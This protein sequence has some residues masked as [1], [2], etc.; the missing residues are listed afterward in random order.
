M[1]G[2]ILATFFFG[3]SVLASR[4]RPNPNESETLLSI[5][6]REVFNG[7]TLPYY[8]LQFSTF[9]ILIL[10][11]NTAFAD[12]PRVTSILAQDG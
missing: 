10:A 3:I 12:F 4:L 11:A 2:T 9:A 8:I 5:M 7:E 6:G 1:M